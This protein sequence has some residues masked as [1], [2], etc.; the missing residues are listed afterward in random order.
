MPSGRMRAPGPPPS[1][2]SVGGMAVGAVGVIAAAAAILG[3]LAYRLILW[4]APGTLPAT[5][6]RYAPVA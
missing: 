2:A 1:A 5:A 3:Y 4:P 6:V